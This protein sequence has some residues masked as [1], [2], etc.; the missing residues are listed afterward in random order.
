MFFTFALFLI[1]SSMIITTTSLP[2]DIKLCTS[3][4]DNECLLNTPNYILQ[5]HSNGIK[6]HLDSIDPLKIDSMSVEQTSGPVNILAKL[7]NFDIVG[8]SKAKIYKFSG[9]ENN[10]LD[11]RMKMPIA[12]LLGPY[13]VIGKIFILNISG[14]GKLKLTFKNFD[15]IMSLP[16]TKENRDGKSFIKIEQP[17]MTFDITGGDVSMS[18]LGAISNAFLNSNFNRIIDAIKPAISKSLIEKLSQKINLFF[19]ANSIEELFIN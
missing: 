14:V 8:F 10:L 16:F 11:L 3:F 15:V 1:A 19:E 2:S 13:D 4:N 18:H 9:F 6:N 17:Q 12:T 7:N 5:K